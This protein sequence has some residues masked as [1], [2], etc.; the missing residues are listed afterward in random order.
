MANAVVAASSL[1]IAGLG[2]WL[3]GPRSAGLGCADSLV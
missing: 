2:W 3:L 1:A